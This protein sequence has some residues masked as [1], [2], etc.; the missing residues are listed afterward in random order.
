MPTL[1]IVPGPQEADALIEEA[2]RV[3]EAGSPEAAEPLFQRFLSARPRHVLGLRG[4]AAVLFQLGKKAEAAAVL[5]RAAQLEPDSHEVWS[6][7]GSAQA[8]LKRYDEAAAAFRRAIELDPATPSNYYAL[9]RVLRGLGEVEEAM[10]MFAIAV[11]AKPDEA[12][13]ERALGDALRALNRPR[14]AA[15]AYR[16]AIFLEP[17]RPEAQIALGS[18]YRQEG[19][20][21]RALAIYRR[22]L[23]AHP[24]LA[25]AWFNIGAVL[26]DLDKLEEAAAAY[27]RAVEIDPAMSEA[28]RYLGNVMQKL[29]RSEEARA[30]FARAAEADPDSPTVIA[31][32]LYRARI[33]ADWPVAA[34][35]LARSDAD[36][37]GALAEKREPAMSAHAA[38]FLYDDPALHRDVAVAQATKIT[39]SVHISDERPDPAIAVGQVP[40]RIG[41]LSGDI[42]DHPVS[43]L[44]RGL[45]A[46]HD[47]ERFVVHIYAFGADDGSDY[48]RSIRESAAKFVDVSGMNDANAARA[49]ARDRIDI[50]V[51]LNGQTGSARMGI[52]ARRPAPV[53]AV[54]L[55]YP[56]TGGGTWNDYV[57]ADR[58]VAPPADAAFYVEQLCHLP[59]CYLATDDRQ[60]IASGRMTRADAGLPDDG[61]VFASFNSSYKIEPEIFGV[62]MRI[63]QGTPGAVLWLPAFDEAI[64]RRLREEA[65]ARSV[66][67]AR[68]VF[69]PRIEKQWHLRRLALADLALDTVAY[70]GHT[71]TA[72]ALWGGLP[73]LTTV[74]RS[75]ARRVSASMLAT[76]GV[77]ELIAPSLD[78]YETEAIAL[79]RD[80]DRLAAIRERVAQGR[81]TS[82]LF[83]TAR[84]TRNLERA[85]RVML[86]RRAAGAAPAPI[87]VREGGSDA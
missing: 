46:A 64:C 34:R 68:L 65:G 30:A 73:V 83:D 85:C 74:G 78:A 4:Y 39:R 71:T 81:S 35:L 55:G 3:Y 77:P 47:R 76:L 62:W 82:P 43:H 7:L 44:V 56:G 24:D 63:L 10:A 38:L 18:L 80:R 40:I 16:R 66:D 67:P 32:L 12:R 33:D 41:Y 17:D 5:G 84:F 51:D 86:D 53:Q 79:A 19:R 75:F 28:H 21:P 26:F 58:F 54:W 37:R 25:V 42:G 52:P 1:T 15:A 22:V 69:A 72:D 31:D 59:H 50:L 57:I 11:G 45:F 23:K 13:Y 61:F 70:N 2:M 20:L 29:G 9:G 8:S 87:D 48:R 6:N 60:P 27:R 49:I 14:D 36:V